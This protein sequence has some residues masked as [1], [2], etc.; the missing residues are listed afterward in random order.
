MASSGLGVQ[1]RMALPLHKITSESHTV[2]M[3]HDQHQCRTHYC[4]FILS[5]GEVELKHCMSRWLDAQDGSPLHA[6]VVVKLACTRHTTY[7]ISSSYMSRL[8]LCPTKTNLQGT[9]L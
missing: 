6:E 8:P 7:D 4:L 3:S 5:T 1:G 9:L 2:E